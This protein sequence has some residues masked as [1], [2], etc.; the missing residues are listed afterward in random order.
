[1]D[2]RDDGGDYEKKSYATRRRR[3]AQ[4]VFVCTANQDQHQPP[5]TDGRTDKH[6]PLR[7]VAPPWPAGTRSLAGIASVPS[8]SRVGRVAGIARMQNQIRSGAPR[9]RRGADGGRRDGC[10]ASSWSGWA[11]VGLGSRTVTR[12]CT[13]HSVCTRRRRRRSPVASARLAAVPLRR[14]RTAH[15]LCVCCSNCQRQDLT[16]RQSGA[17]VGS[18]SASVVLCW[19]WVPGWDCEPER[20]TRGDDR[21]LSGR[22]RRRAEVNPNTTLRVASAE[23]ARDLLL[24]PFAVRR[25]SSARPSF[26]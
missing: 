9:H 7:R 26:A 12:D 10:Q 16:D 6:S 17:G 3:L 22:A 4:I 1:M 24:L 13:P 2:D 20:I 21:R 11:S 14:L 19:A 15:L 5:S 8:A 23:S 25:P 18:A